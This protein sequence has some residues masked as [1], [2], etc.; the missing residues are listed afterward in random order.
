M[1]RKEGWKGWD[2]RQKKA[3]PETEARISVGFCGARQKPWLPKS[4]CKSRRNHNG[5]SVMR[6]VSPL[7]DDGLCCEG[8]KSEDL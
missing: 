4:K 3:S 7:Q 8:Q 6:G 2:T 5:K 1:T